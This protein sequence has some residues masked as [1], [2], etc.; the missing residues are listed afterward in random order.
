MSRAPRG[1]QA[2]QGRSVVAQGSHRNAFATFGVFWTS[3]GPAPG[4]FL[5]SPCDD[6]RTG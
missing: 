6:S 3:E 4:P 1:S 5:E 2:A